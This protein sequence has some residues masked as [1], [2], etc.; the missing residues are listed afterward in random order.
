LHQ[1]K[2]KTES[3]NMPIGIII[4]L[5]ACQ[6][7]GKV[8]SV[9][10]GDTLTVRTASETIK[11]RLIHIDSPER[12][13]AF[14]TKARQNLSD[15][16]FGKEVTLERKEKGRYGRLLAIVRID[17]KEANLKQV[18]A[19][20]AWAFLEYRPPANYIE[21]EKKARTAKAGLWAD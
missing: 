9:A 1:Q 10:D 14:G 17:G 13:Q 2:E 12:G 3:E 7:S 4:T 21:V 18:K 15:L 11:V 19:G 20:L 6:L 8:V 5:L 16:T